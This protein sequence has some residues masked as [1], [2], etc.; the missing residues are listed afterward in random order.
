MVIYVALSDYISTVPEELYVENALKNGLPINATRFYRKKFDNA[1]ETH[2][3]SEPGLAAISR[4]Q[5]IE[6]R[7]IAFEMYQEYREL[8]SGINMTKEQS[9]LSKAMFIYNY[10]L[11]NVM[12]TLCQF[13]PGSGN[14][15]GGNPFKNSIYGAIVMHDAVCSGISDAFDC[16]CKLF[17]LESTKLLSVPTDPYGGGHA[18]NSVKIGE[19]WYKVDAA[20]EIGLNPG[21]KISGGKWKDRNFL[22]PFGEI[23]ERACVPAVPNCTRIYPRERIN[24]MKEFFM[25]RGISFE[26]EQSPLIRRPMEESHDKG[27][28]ILER[29]NS[30][31]KS[32]LPISQFKPKNN[33]HQ[34]ET[35]NS[36]GR[37]R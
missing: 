26:Y 27:F 5:M 7:M 23:L 32:R 4:E 22:V 25:S 13:A 14:V 10:L 20:Q 24:Q 29:N 21:H 19:Y 17:D 3:S 8:V 15:F 16:L 11:E 34:E 12:Y 6:L 9:D 18:F 2:V 37:R 33:T 31:A 28:K 30:E 35:T 36:H 1:S